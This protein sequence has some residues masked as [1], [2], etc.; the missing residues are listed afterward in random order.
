[1][2]R[3]MLRKN[4][5]CRMLKSVDVIKNIKLLFMISLNLIYL[6]KLNPSG[7]KKEKYWL[8]LSTF[9]QECHCPLL[10]SRVWTIV[11]AF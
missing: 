6:F 4:L 2:P 1:M 5:I 8:A 7:S 11:V 9:P 10:A 3:L